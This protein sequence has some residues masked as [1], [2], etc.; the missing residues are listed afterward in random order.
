MKKKIVKVK[1]PKSKVPASMQAQVFALTALQATEGWAIMLK[2]MLE[3]IEY[4]EECILSKMQEGQ[5]LNDLEIDRLRDKRGFLKDLIDMPAKY[6]KK[7]EEG[8]ATP[9]NFDPYY[10]NVKDLISDRKRK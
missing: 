7:L 2:S 10:K 6:A 8:S 4:L 5:E 9:E 1:I 3:N